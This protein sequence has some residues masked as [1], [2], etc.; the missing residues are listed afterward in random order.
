MSIKLLSL[1]GWQRWD[2]SQCRHYYTIK[3]DAEN[4]RGG[5]IDLPGRLVLEISTDTIHVPRVK[6]RRATTRYRHHQNWRYTIYK[7]PRNG[8]NSYELGSYSLATEL[9]EKSETI[10]VATLRRW[11]RRNNLQTRTALCVDCTNGG[12][13]FLASSFPQL[14]VHM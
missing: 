14:L 8:K 4:K 2:Q 1:H 10:Q 9:N 11:C 5:K 13:A 6:W 12:F 7:P 3:E